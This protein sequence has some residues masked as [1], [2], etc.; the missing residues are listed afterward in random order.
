MA[1]KKTKW[2]AHAK[3]HELAA[4]IHYTYLV[5]PGPGNLAKLRRKIRAR[6][7]ARARRDAEKEE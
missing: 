2:E 4:L 6:C 7:Y 5:D 3:P 1:E